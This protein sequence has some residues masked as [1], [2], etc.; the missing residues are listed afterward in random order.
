MALLQPPSFIQARTDHTAQEDR[1]Y[2]QGLLNAVGGVGGLAV[3][4]GTALVRAQAAPAMSVIV[5]KERFFIPGTENTAQGMYHGYNDGD[6]TVN[7]A[8]SSPTLPRVDIIVA[9]VRDA[10][11][12]GVNNDLEVR[13]V[14]GTPNASPVPPTTPA[15]GIVLA[16]IAVA[17]NA[18]TVTNANITNNAQMASAKGGLLPVASQAIRDALPL[19]DGLGVYRMDTNVIEIYNG[20]SWDI[21]AATGS[22]VAGTVIGQVSI[23][24]S[25]T[26]AGATEALLA[27]LALTVNVVTGRSYWVDVFSRVAITAA[28]LAG[29]VTHVSQTALTTASPVLVRSIV[30]LETVGATGAFDIPHTRYLWSP[31]VTGAW[32]VGVGVLTV[33]GGG[34]STISNGTSNATLVVTAA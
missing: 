32:N 5:A 16:N 17:A 10:F 7:I 14:T 3:G 20:A 12:S 25:V 19:Y 27:T 33:A 24:G 28:G 23:A 2:L 9:D 4:S 8:A 6:I 13:A 18:T 29:I 15:N 22:V 1:L 26:S 34:N 11:Y 30:R 31:G 21:F